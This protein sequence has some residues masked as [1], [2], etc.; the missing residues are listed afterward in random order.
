MTTRLFRRTY[1]L[2][3]DSILLSGLQIAFSVERTLR[4]RPGA[5]EI[6][7]TNLSEE[8]RRQLER[9]RSGIFVDLSAGYDLT[10]TRVF[11]GELHQVHTDR[12]LPSIITVIQSRD[13]HRAHSA[14]T[15]RSH[16]AGTTLA[17]VVRGLVE[18]MGVDEG[19]LADVLPDLGGVF[20]R[21]VSV[22]GS[23]TDQLDR[24]TTTAGLEWSIQDGALQVL[25]RG[26]ALQRTA[27]RL[28]KDSGLVGSP[29]R[30]AGE[31]AGKITVRTLMIADLVP[32]RLVQIESADVSGFFRIEKAV[33]KGDLFGDQWGYELTCAPQDGAA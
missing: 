18:D 1:S 22:F 3:V 32:G 19:N 25:P 16:R 5:C 33:C 13:G 21:G 10:H 2:Q 26:R 12:Q 4:R 6:K 11:R 8:H 7:I 29:A 17:S 24:M 14:R 23:A 20:A 15:S 30:G 28:T 27:V 31:D 9:L